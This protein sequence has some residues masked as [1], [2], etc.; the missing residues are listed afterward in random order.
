[1][2]GDVCNWHFSQGKYLFSFLLNITPCGVLTNNCSTHI[3]ASKGTFSLNMITEV[4]YNPPL[5]KILCPRQVGCASLASRGPALGDRTRTRDVD[6]VWRLFLHPSWG[7]VVEGV[8]EIG[9][10]CWEFNLGF[11]TLPRWVLDYVLECLIESYKPNYYG[12]CKHGIIVR[13]DMISELGIILEWPCLDGTDVDYE[14]LGLITR[15]RGLATCGTP[16]TSMQVVLVC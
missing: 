15:R 4:G 16:G 11:Q 5:L 7:G 3:L 13:I 9:K 2:R 10:P 12:I 14:S 1:M 6:L 8:P